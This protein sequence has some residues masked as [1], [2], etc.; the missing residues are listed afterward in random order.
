MALAV[1]GIYP[2]RIRRTASTVLR[3][4]VI[5]SLPKQTGHDHT[6]VRLLQVKRLHTVVISIRL[7]IEMY[8]TR[9]KI[10]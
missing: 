10:G 7:N 4:T 6:E 9:V 2:D 5:L 8:I 1:L 3:I